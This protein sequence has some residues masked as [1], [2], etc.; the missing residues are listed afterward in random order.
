MLKTSV[1]LG[2]I[3]Q[4]A[5]LVPSI[6][7]DRQ[8]IKSMTGCYKVKFQFR[9]TIPL[10]KGY[11]LRDLYQSGGLEW[12]TVNEENED[13][14]SLQHIL[15]GNHGPHTSIIKHWRQ[16]WELAPAGLFDFKGFGTWKYRDLDESSDLI[17]SQKVFQVDDS[18][19]YACAAPWIHTSKKSYWECQADTPLPRREYT[20]R[21][22]YQILNRINRH[23]IVSTGHNHIQDNEKVILKGEKRASLAMEKG[24][25][26]Y[27][28]VADEKCEPAKKWWKGHGEFWRD[29]RAVWNKIYQENKILKFDFRK[30]GKTLWMKLFELDEKL[31]NESAYDSKFAQL[32]IEKIILFH[33]VE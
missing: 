15:I 4:G 25:N 23:E 12:I 9:E 16:E 5:E 2:L 13:L 27:T 24:Y 1:I 3:A 32:E 31:S 19:R 21:K 26:T 10:M 22:D 29:A 20:K 14:I 18:P 11:K 6:Q 7:K 17:W 33:M 28:K 30:G 8:A